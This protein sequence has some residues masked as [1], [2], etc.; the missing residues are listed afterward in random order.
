MTILSA[1][2][3]KSLS[4]GSKLSPLHWTNLR[5]DRVNPDDIPALFGFHE[6]IIDIFNITKR[7]GVGLFFLPDDPSYKKVDGL[8]QMR[9]GSPEIFI[10]RNFPLARQRFTTAHEVG[11][12]LRHRLEND[13]VLFRANDF[14][15]TTMRDEREA[16]AFAARLLMPESMVRNLVHLVPLNELARMFGVSEQAM[17]IRVREILR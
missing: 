2:D 13:K 16:N 11:H 8:L 1:V 6:P 7:M 12:L 17:S 14:T 3:T 4:S 5:L 9:N 15:S 10:N